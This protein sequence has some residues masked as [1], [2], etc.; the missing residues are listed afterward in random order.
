MILQTHFST[1]TFIARCL[2][3]GV[4]S[5][6]LLSLLPTWG[7]KAL[8]KAATDKFFLSRLRKNEGLAGRWQTEFATDESFERRE[9][10]KWGSWDNRRPF[11]IQREYLL[12]SIQDVGFDC[13]L[14]QFDG[15]GPNIAESMLRGYYRTNRRAT[16]I[17][18]KT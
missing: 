12:Q 14:E 16:F 6:R 5:P 18:I 13:V 1:D 2:A 4:S 8:A 3:D 17:G 9:T 7:K 11:L 10:A 15:L